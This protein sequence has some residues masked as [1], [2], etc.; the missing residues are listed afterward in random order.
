MSAMHK[1]HLQYLVF[2]MF[3][4]GILVFIPSKAIAQSE[5]KSED[6]CIG[7]H[8]KPDIMPGLLKQH[9]KGRHFKNSVTCI[10]CHS[11][12]EGDKDA[13][14]HEGEMISIIVSPKDC[15]KCHKKE[16]AEFN[17]SMHSKARLL[18]TTGFGNYFSKNFA[19]SQYLK[20]H[21]ET[22]K[23]GAS[24][25]GC[26]QCHGSK[27]KLDKNAQPISHTWPNAGIGR[28]N[29]DGSFGNCSACH[30]GNEF[31]VAQARQPETCANCH[32]ES[33]GDAQIEAYNTS[34]HGATYHTKIE[35]MNLHSTEWIVGKDYFAAP[36]CATC[37][38]SATID[39]PSTHNIDKRMNWS[40]L[41]QQTNTLAVKEKCGL[42]DEVQ[43]S[44][45]KQPEP[46]PAHKE[47]M[48][49]VC[50]ACHS[51]RFSKNFF[52]QY[53][54]ELIEKKWIKPGKELFKQATKV[55][56]AVEKDKYLFFTHSIDFVWWGMCNTQVKS[57]H[58]GAAMMSPGEVTKGNGGLA[59][60]WYSSFMPEIGNI[61]DKYKCNPADKRCDPNTQQAV[62][63]LEDYYNNIKNNPIYSGPWLK[64]K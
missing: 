5:L 37:H 31:S 15:A 6:K 50:K 21:P 13:F 55:L 56:Q 8:S 20:K 54:I 25:I 34:R 9:L 59:A 28:E 64:S 42:P 1:L 62:E 61:I 3:I 4:L 12:K 51:D 19:G 26:T 16:V 53:E 32:N 14:E 33:G 35:Q 36:T 7:C 2:T 10:D 38:M 39:M 24:E 30:E 22:G 63:K 43:K 52:L 49:K 60:S 18:L 11:A 44:R 47:N 45:N 27:I 58:T 17:D 48:K 41:L 40:K 57:V 29:P 23:Y 46:N